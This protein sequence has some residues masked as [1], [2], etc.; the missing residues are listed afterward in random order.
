MKVTVTKYLNVRVGKPRLD[1]PC[2]QYLAPGSELEIDG[3]EYHGDPYDGIDVWYKD[4]AGNYYWSGG[5]H[6]D[7]TTDRKPNVDDYNW[8]HSDYG[9]PQLWSKS[10]GD[11][12]IIAIVD[13]GIDVNH[14]WIKNVIAYRKNFNDASDRV[15]DVTSHGTHVGAIA[16]GLHGISPRS[17]LHIFKVHQEVFYNDKL[18]DLGVKFEFIADSL[19]EILGFIQQNQEWS[20]IINMSLFVSTLTEKQLSELRGL[21]KTI[22][23]AGGLIVCAVKEDDMNQGF[24]LPPA[25]IHEYCISVGASDGYKAALGN[26]INR[27]ANKIDIFAPGFEIISATSG[28]GTSPGSGSSMACA[29]VSGV[30]GLKCHVELQNGR[31]ATLSTIKSALIASADTL[32]INNNTQKKLINPKNFLNI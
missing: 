30:I 24:V 15:E 11:N 9:F 3:Q 32:S 13:S 29:Y 17:P 20:Y 16:S 6:S 4:D 25:S 14:K 8:W 26:N 1:A 2:Y 31:K 7:T 28:G 18:R 12:S 10:K 23:D 21:M 27:Y 5:V 22:V 19:I